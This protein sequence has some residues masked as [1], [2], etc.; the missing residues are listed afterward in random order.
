MNIG[1]ALTEFGWGGVDVWGCCFKRSPSPRGAIWLTLPRKRRARWAELPASTSP[2]PVPGTGRSGPYLSMLITHRV[3]IEA[4]QHMTSMAM[5]TL[6]KKWPKI[7]L[8]PIRSVTLTKG[9]TAT[10]TERSASARDTIR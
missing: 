4:V 9:M 1:C 2:Q 7:H 8:P 3:M 5:N 6:Q 10:A